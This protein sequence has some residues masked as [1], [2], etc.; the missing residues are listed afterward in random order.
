MRTENKI[1]E[2]RSSR[3]DVGVHFTVDLNIED[4]I[5][6]NALANLSRRVHTDFETSYV[7]FAVVGDKMYFFEPEV[8]RAKFLS[9]LNLTGQAV[10]CAGRV[11][12]FPNGEK[13]DRL[14]TVPEEYKHHYSLK[15]VFG[16]NF[17]I[18]PIVPFNR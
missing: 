6:P 7:K 10:L 8:D 9:S 13:K 3:A 15:S 14:V 4:Q 1:S 16:D 17:T 5:D 18:V 2:I 12:F 11:T